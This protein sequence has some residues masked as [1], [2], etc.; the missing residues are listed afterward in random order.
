MPLKNGSV[1]FDRV[2]DAISKIDYRGNFILQTARAEPGKH[3][4]VLLQ[5]KN[6]VA[7]LL[8][9]HAIVAGT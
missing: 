8:K 3:R 1:D 9:N 5:Y 4:D 2:F 6:F 7:E